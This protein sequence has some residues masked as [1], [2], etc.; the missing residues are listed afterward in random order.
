MSVQFTITEG[1]NGEC[2]RC[3]KA[4]GKHQVW[5]EY[6]TPI[7]AQHIPELNLDLP[8]VKGIWM[9][10]CDNCVLPFDTLAEEENKLHHATDR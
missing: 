1:Y 8:E 5:E 2:S 9:F 7:P 4:E 6:T 3:M 10:V